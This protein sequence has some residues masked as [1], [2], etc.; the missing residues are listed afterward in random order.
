TWGV[1]ETIGKFEF[2]I[3]NSS[4][5]Y[6]NI[7]TP[8][9]E[10]R[11]YMDYGTTATTLR[12]KGIIERV[13]KQDFNLVLTGRGPA[14][15]YVGKNVT[16]SATNKARSTILSEI[17]SKYFIDLTTTNLEADS[18]TA[19]VNYFDKPFWEVVEDV[20]NQGSHDAYI[21]TSF[22]FHYFL[23]GSRK[24]TTDAVIHEFNLVET[25]DFAPD[26]SFIYNKIKVY[27]IEEDG[28][29]IIATAEDTTSQTSFKIKELKITDS[30][31]TTQTQAQAR[32][33]YELSINKDPPNIGFV[34]SLGLPTLTPGENLRVSDPLNGLNPGFFDVFEF[35]HKFDN[36]KPFMTEIKIKKERS[37]IPFIL[38][39]RIKIESEITSV[40]N[41]N[42]MDYSKIYNFNS[43]SGTH[44]DTVITDGVLKLVSGASS[45]DWTSENVSL[46]SDIA[47]IEARLVGSGLAGTKTFISTNS[48]LTFREINSIGT[49]TAITPSGTNP[50]S[51]QIKIEIFSTTTEIDTAAILYKF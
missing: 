17:I 48:G 51:F 7:F 47:S 40:N 49:I 8:Y 39:K 19:T 41:P 27:G 26:A 37:S 29:P 42:E 5:T 36:D 12:F 32:A 24:N 25:G 4:Q 21:D 1:T 6:L 50:R 13:S 45:G 46:T 18:T 38:K 14:T 28:I 30:N 33:D 20:C 44:N 35:T 15:K 3:D 10:L 23:S 22:D 31:I 9:D 16:Y 11:V 43:D 34:T 2:K